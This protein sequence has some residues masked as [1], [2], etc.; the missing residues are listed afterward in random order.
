MQH[1]SPAGQKVLLKVHQQVYD[2]A[3]AHPELSALLVP[4]DIPTNILLGDVDAL[5]TDFSS[6]YFDALATGIPVVFFAPDL[7]EYSMLRG[8]YLDVADLPGPLVTDASEAGRLVAGLGSGS[9]QDPLD[10][11]RV[12]YRRAVE[13]ERG[14]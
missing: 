5:V 14:P 12:A 8:L 11:H 2:L 9:D 1:A 10:T 4:N 13:K 3:R 7:Q 6:I